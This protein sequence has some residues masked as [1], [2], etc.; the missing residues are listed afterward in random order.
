MVS[1]DPCSFGLTGEFAIL[2]DIC[3]RSFHLFILQ[4]VTGRDEEKKMGTLVKED[5]GRPDRAST[6]VR[7][8]LTLTIHIL[9]CYL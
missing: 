7:H 8:N 4:S 3:F 2:V 1:F 6:M 5:F 9:W